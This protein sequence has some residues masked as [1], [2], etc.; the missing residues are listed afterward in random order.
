MTS[1][2]NFRNV[3]HPGAANRRTRIFALPANF[4]RA[5]AHEVVRNWKAENAAAWKYV[6]DVTSDSSCRTGTRVQASSR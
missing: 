3:P 2:A 1:S 6:L 5:L 4:T